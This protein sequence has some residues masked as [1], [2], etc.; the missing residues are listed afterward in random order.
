MGAISI[1]HRQPP[2]DNVLMRRALQAA[3]VRTETLA[4]HCLP[5]TMV[6]PECVSM[7]MCGA[8]FSTE[9]GSDIIR[10]PSIAKARDL[11]KQTGFNLNVQT[12]DWSSIAQRWNQNEPVA[13]RG[14][15]P[16]PVVYTG[17]DMSDPLGNPGIGFN[18]SD[19]KTWGY[20][21]PAL[22]PLIAA[23]EAD[24]DPAKRLVMAGQMQTLAYENINLPITG[25]FAAPAVWR[26]GLKGVVDLGFPITWNMERAAK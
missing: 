13:K 7:F 24:S 19:N 18:C 25:Q 8:P 12:S 5:E 16:V 14:W 10:S 17:F 22:T 6:Q 15:N 3:L 1:N 23:C 26:A 11:L 2:F 20:C 4:A 9:A 21:T